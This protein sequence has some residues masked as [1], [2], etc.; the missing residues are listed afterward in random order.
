MANAFSGDQSLISRLDV[1]RERRSTGHH[2]TRGK[3]T[4]ATWTFRMQL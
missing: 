3:S 1:R 4:P 2:G